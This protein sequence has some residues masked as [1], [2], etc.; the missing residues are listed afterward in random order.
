MCRSA[1]PV[2]ASCSVR[3]TKRWATYRQ[4]RTIYRRM[5]PWWVVKGNDAR[6]LARAVKVLEECSM[7]VKDQLLGHTD[8]GVFGNRT[9]RGGAPP[10]ISCLPP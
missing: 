10:R 2:F 1:D 6:R 3:L 4:S 7:R 5:L 9:K 8:D